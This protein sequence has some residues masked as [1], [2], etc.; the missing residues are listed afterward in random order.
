MEEAVA[1]L[2][3]HVE[4]AWHDRCRDVLL[5][6]N[7]TFAQAWQDWYVFHNQFPE[8]LTYGAGTYVEIGVNNP[9]AISNTLFFDKCLGWRGVCFEPATAWHDVIRKTRSCTLVPKCVHSRENVG[10]SVQLVSH[11][12]GSA[13]ARIAVPA[14]QE[15]GRRLAVTQTEMQ[16]VDA[17]DELRALGWANT[18]ID[19][20]SVDVEGAEPD[21]LRCFPFDEFTPKAILVETAQFPDMRGVDRFFHRHGYHNRET[22]TVF[23]RSHHAGVINDHLFVRNERPKRVPVTHHA[24][25]H[26]ARMRGVLGDSCA[27]W[28]EW[29]PEL[30]DN[31]WSACTVS[32]GSAS[33]AY[34]SANASASVHHIHNLTVRGSK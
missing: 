26:C 34:G 13:L 4:P 20:L 33:A 3:R 6:S 28:K 17:G 1:K 10:V 16:C 11:G 22:F 25:L 7:S 15:H 14:R 27:P 30:G 9:T 24:D 19:L 29:L 12:T 18:P 23:D 2:L 8:R 32:S 5:F 21:V 31:R